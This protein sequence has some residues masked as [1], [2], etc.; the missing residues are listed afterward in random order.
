MGI[1]QVESILQLKLEPISYYLCL[2]LIIASS[3]DQESVRHKNVLKYN[4]SLGLNSLDPAFSKDQVSMWACSHIYESLF[5]MDSQCQ[6]RPLLIDSYSISNQYLDYYFKVK[7][8]VFFHKNQCFYTK[9]ST[10]KLTSYDIVYSL[11]RLVHPETASPGSWVLSNHLDSIHPFTII[12]SF[13]FILHLQRPFSP[14]IQVLT[15]PYCGIVPK[16]AVEYYGKNFRKHPVGTGPFRMKLW[17]EGYALF[18]QKNNLYYQKDGSGQQLPYLDY[19]KI[20]FNEN[21]KTEWLSFQKN[22]LSF[23]TTLDQS[24]LKE[25]FDPLGNLHTKWISKMNVSKKEYLS[26]EYLAILVKDGRID[27]SSPWRKKFVRKAA[28]FAINRAEIVQYLKNQLATPAEKGFVAIGM[29]NYDTSFIGYQFQPE[30]AKKL[31]RDAGY[32]TQ[33]KPQIELHINNTFV[34]MAELIS[35]Q[36]KQVGFDVR[37]QLHAS[38]MISRMAAEG[39]LDFFRR[40]WIADYADAENFLACFYSQ[41][42]SPPNYTRF[43]NSNFDRLYE[44]MLIEPNTNSRKKQILEMEKILIEESPFIPIFYDQSI[45]LM[46]KNIQGL[47]QNSLNTLDLRRVRFL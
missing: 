19:V 6:A 47:E 7:K 30:L 24:V 44:A 1:Y 8:N 11:S 18:L 23:I 39:K 9:D 36:L 17:D 20:T 10:R 32:Q 5:I 12:D 4:L 40:S 42:S 28:N 34:E 46:Q 37:I 38:D 15:M 16:E 29:P 26:T 27:S 33:Y 14:L 31:L 43:S 2:W 21:K 13:Q 3:C 22:D 45:R 41:N 25:V 35:Y